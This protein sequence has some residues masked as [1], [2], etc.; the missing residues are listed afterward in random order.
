MEFYFYF[1]KNGLAKTG[2]AELLP[3]A[4]WN[5]MSNL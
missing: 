2:A 3:P 1:E 5:I 4:L